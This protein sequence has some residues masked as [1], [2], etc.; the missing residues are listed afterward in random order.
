[1]T[2]GRQDCDGRQNLRDRDDDS[3]VAVETLR[4]SA[5]SSAAG[6]RKDEERISLFWRVFGGTLL[7]IAALVVITVYNH[8][9]DTLSDL[10]KG[11]NQLHEGR[12]ELL[13]KDEFSTR[14]SS[15]WTSLKELQQVNRGLVALEEK[16]R[17]HDQQLDRQARSAEEDRKDFTRRLEEERKELQR[18]LEEQRKAHQDE[19]RELTGKL[20]KLAERL[21]KVEG[22]QPSKAPSSKN[23]AED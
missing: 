19:R 22:R 7:S 3:V 23:A 14:L 17:T 13:R 6:A 16:A 15:V 18:K 1:M 5:E 21:A 11:M 10:R 12:A 2:K 9:S 4:N 8:I 20:Q